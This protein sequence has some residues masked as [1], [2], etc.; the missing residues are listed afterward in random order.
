LS[1]VIIAIPGLMYYFF[2]SSEL[3]PWN[4]PIPAV[5]PETVATNGNSSAK[6]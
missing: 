1:G 3:Q 5:D 2:G 4:N 6:K